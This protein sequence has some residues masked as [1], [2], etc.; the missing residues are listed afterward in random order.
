MVRVEEE[1]V[2]ELAGLLRFRLT[3]AAESGLELLVVTVGLGREHVA[4]GQ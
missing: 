1:L 2:E 4:A 3:R